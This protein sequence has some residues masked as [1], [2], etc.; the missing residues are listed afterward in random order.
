MWKIEN[1]KNFSSTRH[2]TAKWWENMFGIILNSCWYRCCS[3][4]TESNKKAAKEQKTLNRKYLLWNVKCA[5]RDVFWNDVVIKWT[6]CGVWCCLMIC[7]CSET[8][9]QPTTLT[10]VTVSKVFLLVRRKWFSY[11]TTERRTRTENWVEKFTWRLGV[12]ESEQTAKSFGNFHVKC[13]IQSLF[14][15]H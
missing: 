15:V 12:F 8:L 13:E 11:V 2:Y 14:T 3:T 6:V 10:V 1:D 9:L 7:N 4:T 5:Q